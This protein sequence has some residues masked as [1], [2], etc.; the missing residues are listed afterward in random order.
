MAESSAAFYQS[1]VC[2]QSGN[3]TSFNVADVVAKNVTLYSLSRLALRRNFW[4][5][6]CRRFLVPLKRSNGADNE[7]ES[8]TSGRLDEG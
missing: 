6:Q 8:E 5:I 3:T 1:H 4:R 2:G 7:V